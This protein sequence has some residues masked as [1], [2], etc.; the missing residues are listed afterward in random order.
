MN[1]QEWSKTIILF[2]FYVLGPE[3]IIVVDTTEAEEVCLQIFE[4]FQAISTK[5]LKA[6]IM[7]HFHGGMHVYMTF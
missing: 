5:P 1:V 2:N 3:G 7:T 6:I 4:E